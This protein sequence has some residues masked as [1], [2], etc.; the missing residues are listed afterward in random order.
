MKSNRECRENEATRDIAVG[1]QSLVFSYKEFTGERHVLDPLLNAEQCGNQA[2]SKL[3][4]IVFVESYASN[5]F[6]SIQALQG[7]EEM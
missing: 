1:I 3:V 6:G 4:C 7:L 5:L 2:K